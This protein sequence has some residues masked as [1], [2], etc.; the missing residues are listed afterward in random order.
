MYFQTDLIGY[1]YHFVKLGDE[2]KSLGIGEVGR[3]DVGCPDKTVR[4]EQLVRCDEFCLL[5]SLEN[6]HE[7][8]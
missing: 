6:E 8:N 7:K 2:S 4:T 3:G 1:Y 5:M